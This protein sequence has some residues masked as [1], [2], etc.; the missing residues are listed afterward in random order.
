MSTSGVDP[1]TSTVTPPVPPPGAPREPLLTVGLITAAA[2]AILALAAA[3]GLSLDDDAQAAILGLVAVLAP[4][5]VAVVA[6]ARTW[7]P[8]TV[9]AT[10]NAELAKARRMGTP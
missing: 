1:E 9:R 4:V 3:F 7:S 6:R 5:I 10:V 8:A 2:V